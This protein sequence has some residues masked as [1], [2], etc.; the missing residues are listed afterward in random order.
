VIS[1]ELRGKGLYLLGFDFIGEHLT[2]INIT[3]P[4][5]IVQIGQVMGKRAEIEM[6]DE[7]E[8]MRLT[9]DR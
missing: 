5:T 6:V 1:R 9:Q 2:E 4:T 7:L 8:R 3:S